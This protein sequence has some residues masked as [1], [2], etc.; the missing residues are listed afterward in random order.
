MVLTVVAAAGSL[1]VAVLSTRSITQPLSEAVD[2]ARRVAEGDLTST[3]VATRSDETGQ[4]MSALRHM[5]DSLIRIV[6]QVRGGTEA[7][8]SDCP[9]SSRTISPP[10]R[11]I[12]AGHSPKR[13][14]L[15]TSHTGSVE[16]LNGIRCA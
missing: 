15:G 12:T 7:I 1:A 9:A 16:R 8:T 5:N 3:I 6:A 10:A 2:I 13:T 14:T 4:M 11:S